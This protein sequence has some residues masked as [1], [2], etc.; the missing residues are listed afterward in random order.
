MAASSNLVGIE[1]AEEDVF[2]QHLH[3]GKKS[4]I[5]L[6][7]RANE[8]VYLW[9]DGGPVSYTHWGSGISSPINNDADC[10]L[11]SGRESNYRWKPSYC[12]D[13]QNFTC[14]TGIILCRLIE[15]L[16]RVTTQIDRSVFR[17]VRSKD[18]SSLPK[19]VTEI[20]SIKIFKQTLKN[21]V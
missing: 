13:C 11:S 4:W 15:H 17:Y 8:G 1:S 16:P 2:V 21:L 14:K 9:T 12:D 3:R 19:E 7:D 10:V 5:G 18:C 20:T 6:N